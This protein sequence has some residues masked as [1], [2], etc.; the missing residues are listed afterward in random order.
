MPLHLDKHG[1]LQQ[2]WCQFSVLESAP[3]VLSP[4]L[5][6]KCTKL[7]NATSDAEREAAEV[8]SMDIMHK[9]SLTLCLTG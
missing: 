5:C 8:S 7:L 9:H 6:K 2:V 3:P 1:P 4:L